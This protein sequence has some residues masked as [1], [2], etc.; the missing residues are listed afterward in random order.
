MEITPTSLNNFFASVAPKSKFSAIL[1]NKGGYI[2]FSNSGRR[3]S[4]KYFTLGLHSFYRCVEDIKDNLHEFSDY[5]KYSEKEWRD[6]GAQFFMD[7]PANAMSTVQTKALFTTLSKIISWATESVSFDDDEIDLKIES[8]EKTLVYLHKL[9]NLYTPRQQ[10][11][12]KLSPALQKIYF[13]APGTGKSHKIANLLSSVPKDQIARVTFH[14]EYDYSS[15]VGGYKPYTDSSGDVKYGFVPQIFSVTYIKAWQNPTMDF[16]LVIEEINRGNCAEI[17]GDLFQLLDRNSNYSITPSQDLY[18]Y[19]ESALADKGHEGLENGKMNLPPNLHLI[20]SMN[21]SDQSLFPMDSAFKRRW[22][23]E[24]VPIIYEEAIEGD[25]NPSY[26]YVVDISASQKFR[27]IDFIFKVNTLIKNNPNL[28]SDKCLG[29]Y[30]VKTVSGAI[31]IDEFINKVIFYL[32]LDVFKD[33][34]DSI[35]RQDGMLTTFEDFFPIDPN[36]IN[37]VIKLLNYLGVTIHEEEV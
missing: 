8:L 19:L 20:A 9:I 2:N 10:E 31:T 35:F 23:W 25:P 21:T 26:Y 18:G 28:G 27:W 32:W 16:Y 15:F 11:Q 24:Y 14:P 36:G 6:L 5:T 22:S 3:D 1:E 30:F 12:R 17:F 29:N 37:N 33:E 4:V 13:G 7:D 34:E